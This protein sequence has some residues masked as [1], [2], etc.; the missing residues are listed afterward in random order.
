MVVTE[1][2]KGEAVLFAED[3][4]P[5][6]V[7]AEIVNAVFARLWNLSEDSSDELEDVEALSFGMGQQRVI[8]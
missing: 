2:V 7:G 5:R 6:S 4:G 1:R 3:P 8:M